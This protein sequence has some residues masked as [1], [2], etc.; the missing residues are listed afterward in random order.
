MCPLWKETATLLNQLLTERSV[1]GPPDRPVFIGTTEAAITR[2][3]IYKII[4]RY[5]SQSSRRDRMVDQELFLL[6]SGATAQ[7]CI[8]LKLGSR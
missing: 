2:F 3:G 6:T 5:T 1:A 4:R 8:F 7:P